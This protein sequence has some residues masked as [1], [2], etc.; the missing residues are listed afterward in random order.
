MPSFTLNTGDN[1]PPFVELMRALATA[2]Q[3]V[4]I[5]DSAILR[6]SDSG[7]TAAQADIIFT[8]G[9]TE[10]MTCA[11][12]GVETCIT[13]GTLTG[14]IDRLRAK[15]L[16]ERW[17]D[18]YDARRTIVALTEKGESL[19]KKL[20]PRHL[21]RLRERFDRMSSADQRR[22]TRLLEVIAEAFSED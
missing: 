19:Y 4:S 13:K 1:A 9:G 6:D 12:L 16:V 18:A 14:V 22:A 3:A 2:N 7:M 5:Y 17:A 21:S 11:D 15:G 20:L 10:G 8:L